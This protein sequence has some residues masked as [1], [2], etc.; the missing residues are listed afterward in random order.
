[1]AEL[2]REYFKRAAADVA[3]RGDNDTLPFDVDTAF[4]RTSQDPLSDLALTYSQE[5][6]AAGKKAAR[7]AVD[8][9]P[10]FSERFLL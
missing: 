10:I 5:L 9:L 7:E 6:E 1:M 8:T 4:V 3:A 2:K